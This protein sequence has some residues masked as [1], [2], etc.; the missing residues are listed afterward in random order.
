MKRKEEKKLNKTKQT[1]NQSINQSIKHTKTR[2]EKGGNK[3]STMEEVVVVVSSR[4]STS[5]SGNTNVSKSD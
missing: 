5:R 2:M 1:N 4:R 3:S